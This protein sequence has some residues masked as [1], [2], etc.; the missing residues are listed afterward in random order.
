MKSRL[1]SFF[2]ECTACEIPNSHE[3]RAVLY[4][5]GVCKY[6]YLDVKYNIMYDSDKSIYYLGDSKSVIS[7][8]FNENVWRLKDKSN[9]FLTAVSEASYRSLAIGNYNWTITNDTSM[10]NHRSYSRF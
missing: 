6:S 10:C 9:P 8:D 7:Y 3:K 1:V 5:R 4:L 2:K